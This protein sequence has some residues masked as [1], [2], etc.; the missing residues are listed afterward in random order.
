MALRWASSGYEPGQRR[1]FGQAGGRLSGFKMK[2]G[3][4]ISR[5]DGPRIALPGGKVGAQ[6]KRLI[7]R[8]LR[9][10]SADQEWLRCQ[11]GL[12]ES[13]HETIDKGL[14]DRP[15]RSSRFTDLG[16]P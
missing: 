3:Q 7:A 6:G 16:Q 15:A 13:G 2:I 1:N 5:R 11:R 14:V 4:E 10:D 9:L 12:C 8:H